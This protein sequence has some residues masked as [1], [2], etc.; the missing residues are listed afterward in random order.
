V[1]CGDYR[2]GL[3]TF[4]WMRGEWDRHNPDRLW[5]Y[6]SPAIRQAPEPLTLTLDNWHALAV[7]I[8]AR[9][10]ET[11][12]Q[13]LLALLK[14]R[15]S[16]RG[17]FVTLEENDYP[18]VGLINDEEAV[19]FVNLL[20]DQGLIQG[21]HPLYSV[22]PKGWDH[23]RDRRSVPGS[24][25]LSHAAVDAALAAAIAHEIQSRLPGTEIFVASQ[26]GQI[27]TGEKWLDAIEQKLRAGDTYIILLTSV[28]IARPWIW[29]ETGT[30]WF[31]DKRILPV[32]AT[33]LDISQVPHPLS[34]RQVNLDQT[35]GVQ[36]FLRDFGV[37]VSLPEATE[38]V[39]RLR[40]SANHDRRSE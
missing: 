10:P 13:K 20:R 40:A 9:S 38:I 33:G 23:G 1:Y 5:P 36:Q 29:F 15:S 37:E 21:T 8:E 12:V 31:S 26:P 24:V 6:L 2:I 25:F 19:Y 30:V 16:H 39:E 14:Q 17:Q 3:P 18:L 32:L 34:A 27:R 22:T 28:S 11:K 35:A 7:E 4:N